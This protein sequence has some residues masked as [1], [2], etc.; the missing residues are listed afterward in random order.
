[1]ERCKYFG[2]LVLCSGFN[3]LSSAATDKRH[4]RIAGLQQKIH[5]FSFVQTK[6]KQDFKLFSHNY[7]WLRLYSLVATFMFLFLFFF[8]DDVTQSSLHIRSPTYFST[9]ELTRPSK[10]ECGDLHKAASRWLTPRSPPELR[11]C[12]LSLP[13]LSC[14]VKSSPPPSRLDAADYH[15]TPEKQTQ[16]DGISCCICCLPLKHAAQ[17][18]P[19]FVI[20]NICQNK[21]KGFA[22]EKSDFGTK[23]SSKKSRSLKQI[24]C[25]MAIKL[26]RV[27][28]SNSQISGRTGESDFS[29]VQ[30]VWCNCVCVCVFFC[31][32]LYFSPQS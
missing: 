17:S 24:Q 13:L 1:M 20:S 7:P 28:V 12:C 27:N 2:S 22:G 23:K 32:F 6:L 14:P 15:K 30:E 21:G 5:L 9:P 26:K 4:G 31:A 16:Q 10:L 29:K 8:D 11:C 19:V 3:V 18:G 25:E